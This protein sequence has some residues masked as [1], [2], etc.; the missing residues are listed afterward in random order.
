MEERWRSGRREEGKWRWQG[1]PPT[2]PGSSWWEEEREGEKWRNSGS[3]MSC[4]WVSLVCFV[5]LSPSLLPS[6]LLRSFLV[7]S[8]LMSVLHIFLTPFLSFICFFPQHIF[9]SFIPSVSLSFLLPFHSPSIPSFLFAFLPFLCLSAPSFFLPS[10]PS[11]TPSNLFNSFL[12]PFF[13]SCPS[14]AGPSFFPP[15]FHSLSDCIIKLKKHQLCLL[16]SWTS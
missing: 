2:G 14:L 12:L 3:V 11:L 4:Q 8:F 1:L 5:F 13:F 9:F 7:P 10:L 15:S 16:V 6:S